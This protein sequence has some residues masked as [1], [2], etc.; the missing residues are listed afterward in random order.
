[1]APTD[2][3]SSALSFHASASGS[4]PTPPLSPPTGAP[5]PTRN[6]DAPPAKF[7]DLHSPPSMPAKG[8][9]QCDDG[10]DKYN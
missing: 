5:G 7:I 8:E 1:M 2:T 6:A 9:H 10:H 3:G 4:A